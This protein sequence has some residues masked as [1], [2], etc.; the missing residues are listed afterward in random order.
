[1]SLGKREAIRINA[2]EAK[3]LMAS[4]AYIKFTAMVRD[5]QIEAFTSSTASDT[6][7]REEAHAILRALDQLD[8]K[9]H[10]ALSAQTIL[11][12]KG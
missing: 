4:D 3:W 9:L 10:A 6:M 7:A 2:D 11:D 1:M 5:E 12:K 8:G